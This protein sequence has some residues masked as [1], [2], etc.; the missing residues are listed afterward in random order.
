MKTGME[1]ADST[2]LLVWFQTDRS[3]LRLRYE[4]PSLTIE[5][6]ELKTCYEEYQLQIDMSEIRDRS[7]L[8]A[9]GTAITSIQ[10]TECVVGYYRS[11]KF[12]K[13]CLDNL[14]IASAAT[15]AISFLISIQETQKA[16]LEQCLTTKGNPSCSEIV[17]M[18]N[19]VCA[20]DL[21]EKTR[22]SEL[23]QDVSLIESSWN[24]SGNM[25]PIVAADLANDE[26][27]LCYIL[28]HN[29]IFKNKKVDMSKVGK[30]PPKKEG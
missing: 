2:F 3:Y 15:S 19:D 4:D 9:P 8:Y 13:K 26:C 20:Y 6:V 18:R 7:S 5:E 10:Y 17:F 14:K 28:I 23:L 25:V 22:K 21:I 16:K 1:Q 29:L 27:L 12:F 30:T 11:L 24:Y